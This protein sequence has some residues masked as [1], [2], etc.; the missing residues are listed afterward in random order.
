M[1]GSAEREAT[2][3]DELAKLMLGLHQHLVGLATVTS[4]HSN[5]ST[6]KL[7]AWILP[8]CRPLRLK[9][10]NTLVNYITMP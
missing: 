8:D 4:L 10:L 9:S 1:E 2:L 3:A 6:Q 5:D 7:Y